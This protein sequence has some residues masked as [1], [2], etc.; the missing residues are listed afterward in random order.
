MLKF[1]AGIVGTDA[2]AL[3]RAAAKIR[4]TLTGGM[5]EIMNAIWRRATRKVSG[6]VLR[7]RSG[8]L[9]RS[10]GPPHVKATTTGVE[11][12]LGA[13]AIYARIHEEGGTIPAHTVRPRFGNVL[14]WIGP[15]GR[16]VFAKSANIPA[17]RMPKRAFMAPAVQEEL[18]AARRRFTEIVVRTINTA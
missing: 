9:R 7:V 14:R 10:I 15:D 12:T 13:R 3:K 4:P 8:N 16:P 11:G 5:K 17:I 18:P 1:K 6:D 2:K